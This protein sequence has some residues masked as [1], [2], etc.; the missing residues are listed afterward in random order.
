MPKSM[1]RQLLK[2]ELYLIAFIFTP[3]FLEVLEIKHGVPEAEM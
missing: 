1:I 2:K 3:C